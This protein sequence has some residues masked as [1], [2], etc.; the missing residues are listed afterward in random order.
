MNL[1]NWF[2]RKPVVKDV[3]WTRLEIDK[4]LRRNGVIEERARR[5]KRSLTS[6]EGNIILAFRT[7][8]TEQ[9]Y[10][11]VMINTIEME[12]EGDKETIFQPIKVKA[13]FAYWW[14]GEYGYAPQPSYL[15][16]R[17][18]HPALPLHSNVGLEELKKN[19]ID[20][21]RTPTFEKWVKRGRPCFRG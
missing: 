1:I 4:A 21:P 12:G 19:N 5:E 18:N 17:S 11:R 15:I 2:N 13:K 16:I 7:I 20:V 10:S 14:S 9:G 3:Y 8:A 6:E